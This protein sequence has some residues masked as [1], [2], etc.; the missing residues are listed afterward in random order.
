MKR[1]R[2]TGRRHLF[3]R[4]WDAINNTGLFSTG[5]RV[6][7]SYKNNNVKATGTSSTDGAAAE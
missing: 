3:R 7:L 2:R 5:A 6:L 1:E 4:A